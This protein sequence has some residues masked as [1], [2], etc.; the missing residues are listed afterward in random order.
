[1]CVWW[2]VS[3]E[4]EI[5]SAKAELWRPPTQL[6]LIVQHRHLSNPNA[7]ALISFL[8]IVSNFTNSLGDI[9]DDVMSIVSGDIFCSV[10]CSQI[11]TKPSSV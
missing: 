4:A 1:M 5:Y 7:V 3:H 9:T 8:I 2:S 11:I 6:C 10:S